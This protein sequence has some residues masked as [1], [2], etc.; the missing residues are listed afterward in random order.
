MKNAL[1]L[2]GAPKLSAAVGERGVKTGISRRSSRRAQRSTPVS[3]VKKRG[4][5]VSGKRGD[6]D[7]DDVWSLLTEFALSMRHWWISTCYSLDLTPVQGMALRTLD[8]ASPVAMSALAD[9]LACD[10]SNV[11]GVVDKMEARGLIARQ[12]AENDRRVK[13]LVVTEKGRQLR[14]DLLVRA[15]KAPPEIAAM[16]K[17]TRSMLAAGLRS[18]LSRPR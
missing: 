18:F 13:V 15:A 7:G 1:P 2:N 8:P 10:A 6:R 17:Q 16:P 5:P 11:T 14:Q 3:A 4:A 12:G 9:T